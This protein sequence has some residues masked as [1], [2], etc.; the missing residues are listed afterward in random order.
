M[1]QK[2]D[3]PSP[4][5]QCAWLEES[6]EID[7]DLEIAIYLHSDVYHIMLDV[8]IWK[9]NDRKRTQKRDYW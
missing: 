8:G 1:L 7:Y 5:L 3:R 9:I 4:F 6:N 2:Y